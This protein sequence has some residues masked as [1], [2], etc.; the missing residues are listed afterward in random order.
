MKKFIITGAA[1][2]ALA[3]PAVASA[4]APD[5]SVTFNEA[6]GVTAENAGDLKA[7]AIANGDNLIGWGSSALTHNGQFISGKASRYA[8]LAAPEGQP[9]RSGAGRAGRHRPG[10]PQVAG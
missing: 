2:V 3:V 10:Q 1:L 6:S 7:E 4:D 9:L 8:G 5:G